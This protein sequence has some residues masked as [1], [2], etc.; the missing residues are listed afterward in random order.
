MP[1]EADANSKKAEANAKKEQQATDD[2]RRIVQPSM[3]RNSRL[4][5]AVFKLGFP[6]SIAMLLQSTSQ[7]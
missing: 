5:L 2:I 3:K 1:S 4:S 6:L 7:R